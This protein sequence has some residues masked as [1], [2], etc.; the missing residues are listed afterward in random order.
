M[1]VVGIDPGLDGGIA[2]FTEGASQPLVRA[3][4]TRTHYSGKGREI[5][6]SAL[7]KWLEDLFP[8]QIPDLAVIERVRNVNTG[9][10]QGAT[11]MFSFG[12][13]FGCVRTVL[14]VIGGSS[15]RWPVL[16]AEPKVWQKAI[17]TG[18]NRDDP[19]KAA[20]AYV[21]RRFPELS[22]RASERCQKPHSGIVD[23]VCIALYGLAQPQA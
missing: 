17:L 2:V 9:R 5:D 23:A 3:L 8:A 15:R 13:G 4:P 7:Y 18:M 6:A 12:D 10:K 21:A 14:D 11:S 22:L 19:K 20:L 1:Q 16:F